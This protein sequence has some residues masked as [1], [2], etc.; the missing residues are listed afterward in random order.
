VLALVLAPA[1]TLATTTPASTPSRADVRTAVQRDV[2]VHEFV[3][4][5]VR[6]SLKPK[7][8]A[9]AP[10]IADAILASSRDR[11]INP[12]LVAAIIQTE[13]SFRPDVVGL[14]G[15]IGLMQLKPASAEWIARHAA[16]PWAGPETLKDPATN[17]RIGSAYLSM[18]R[19]RFGTEGDLYLAAYNMG[20]ARL[21]RKLAALESPQIYSSRTGRHLARIRAEYAAA[22]GMGRQASLAD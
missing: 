18:L 6:K 13:S 10:A 22:S 9:H 21:S 15:E 20:A 19:D 16:I 12:L 14:H 5:Y 1:L 7:W 2:E 8:S 3:H 17:I 4:A 11:R